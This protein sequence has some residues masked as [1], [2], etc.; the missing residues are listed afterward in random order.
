METPYKPINNK[1]N[2][3]NVQMGFMLIFSLVNVYPVIQTV[4]S[5]FNI[6]NRIILLKWARVILFIQ[7]VKSSPIKMRKKKIQCVFNVMKD[8]I[9]M[10]INAKDVEM[11]AL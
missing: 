3:Q 1:Y 7:R 11:D 9:Y 6:P 10:I 2:V 4:K 8:T 5:A